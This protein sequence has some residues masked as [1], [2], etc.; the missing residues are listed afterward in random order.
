MASR[1]VL[2][3]HI[4]RLSEHKREIMVMPQGLISLGALAE[5]CGVEARIVHT[6]LGC[7]SASEKLGDFID[8]WMPDLIFCAIHWH[9][10]AKPSASTLAWLSCEYPEIPIVVG[11]LR[12]EPIIHST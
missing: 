7:F 9:Q 3:L 1:R 8:G 6:G 11:G 12:N 5:S 2:S 4:P 10:Q